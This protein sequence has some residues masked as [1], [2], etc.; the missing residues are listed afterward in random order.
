MTFVNL[1]V[2]ILEPS[3]GKAQKSGR[4]ECLWGLYRN[5]AQIGYFN[6]PD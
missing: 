1:T 4:M 2:I 5:W 6:Q 3:Y